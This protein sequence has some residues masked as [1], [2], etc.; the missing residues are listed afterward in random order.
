MGWG[1]WDPNGLG[2]VEFHW[3]VGLHWVEG[4]GVWGGGIQLGWLESIGM[5]DDGVCGG[6][7]PLG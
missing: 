2:V 7:I 6:G 5:G 4:N 1:W 3:L